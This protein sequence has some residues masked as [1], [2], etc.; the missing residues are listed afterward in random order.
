[1]D[2]GIIVVKNYFK[3]IG[4]G[5]FIAGSGILIVLFSILQFAFTAVVGLGMIWWAITEFIDGSIIIGLL[6]LLI[7]TPIAIAISYWAF[8]F[9]LFLAIFAGIIWGIAS[10]FGFDISFGSAWSIVWLV[11]KVVI[12]GFMAFTGVTEFI[13]A[14]RSKRVLGFFKGN[15]WGILL[16]CFLFWLF[17]L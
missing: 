15:W 3:S 9:I 5:G 2:Y 16:F 4:S 8:L 13:E 14:S 11:I 17:F 1:M 10:L 6:V 7:G 12:L